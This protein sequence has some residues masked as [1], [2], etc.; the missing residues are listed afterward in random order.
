MIISFAPT[1][2]FHLTFIQRIKRRFLAHFL[3]SMRDFD[4]VEDDEESGIPGPDHR[5]LL[6]EL[7]GS[8]WGED[9][10]DGTPVDDQAVGIGEGQIIG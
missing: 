8:L 1:T 10:S 7:F 4:S 6:E 2:S 9:D 5:P 3:K